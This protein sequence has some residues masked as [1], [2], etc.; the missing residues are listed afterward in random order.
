[1]GE[2]LAW[3]D[4]IKAELGFDIE[5]FGGNTFLLRSVPSIMVDTDWEEFILDLLP[6]L[7]EEDF[8]NEKIIEKIVTVMSCHGAIK[9]GQRMNDIEIMELF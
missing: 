9:A 3:K 8:L 5:H 1:M 7:D 4:E 2:C 6:V